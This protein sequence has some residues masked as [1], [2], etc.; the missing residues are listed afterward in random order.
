M[1]TKKCMY[2]TKKGTHCQRII[3]SGM[4]GCKT[5]IA[6]DVNTKNSV[7][8]FLH[9]NQCKDQK[10]MVAFTA[11]WCNPCKQFKT[12]LYTKTQ[13]NNTTTLVEEK[14]DI[15]L[16]YNTT[17]PVLVITDPPTNIIQQYNVRGYPTVLLFEPFKTKE[18]ININRNELLLKS[19]TISYVTSYI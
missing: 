7:D 8:S 4:K 9:K 18:P 13:H 12:L 6:E 10:C 14:K 3:S 19:A 1:S 5:H 17:I 2:I 11:S 16:L 15:Y